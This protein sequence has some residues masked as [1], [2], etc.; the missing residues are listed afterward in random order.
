MN[1][2]TLR[3]IARITFFAMFFLSL[4][5]MLIGKIFEDTFKPLIIFF[6][7]GIFNLLITLIVI[8]IYIII[9]RGIKDIIIKN[10]I[11]DSLE[12][13]LISIGAYTDIND[14]I[15]ETPKIHI[16]LKNEII[17]IQYTNVNIRNKINNNI[18]VLSTAL[19]D[20]LIVYKTYVS[21]DQ[22][23]LIIEFE[24]IKERETFNNPQDYLNKLSCG[25]D[26]SVMYID[27]RSIIELKNSPHMLISGSTGYG[28]SFIVYQLLIEAII[29]HYEFIVFDIKRTYQIFSNFGKVIVNKDEILPEFRKVREELNERKLI[30]DEALKKDPTIHATDLNLPIRFIVVEEFLSLSSN[31]SKK[32]FEELEQLILDIAVVGRSLGY[33]L[34]LITQVSSAQSLSSNIRSNCSVRMVCGNSDRTILETAF[35]KGNVPEITQKFG[36]GEGLIQ[37]EGDISP[38]SMPYLNFKIQDV[39][40]I[41]NNYL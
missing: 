21:K 13:N 39:L 14:K 38:F 1:K 4:P 20:N 19:P 3:D 12:Y 24:Q 8:F 6:Y 32:E 35:G 7:I 41:I 29:K 25:K 5:L 31:L 11:I 33:S 15:I 16:D 27:N 10:K 23:Y 28:K 37:I 2:T 18:D 40:N 9:N 22:K 26:N 34:I 36:K 30:L 17:K